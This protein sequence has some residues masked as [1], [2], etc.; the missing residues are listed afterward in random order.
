MTLSSDDSA[1][2]QLDAVFGA[3]NAMQEMLFCA[4]EE[5]LSVLPALPARLTSGAVRG[6]VFPGGTIDIAWNVSGQVDVTVHAVHDLDT[7]LLIG[8][9]E[10][11]RII[12]SGGQSEMKSFM[13]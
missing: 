13:R 9:K 3:V 2:V 7:M 10:Y 8:G 4:Q 5:A 6:L 12:L 11:C 1:T